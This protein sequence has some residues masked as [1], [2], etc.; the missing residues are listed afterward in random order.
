MVLCE[1]PLETVQKPAIPESMVTEEFNIN[2][3]CFADRY[4]WHAKFGRKFPNSYFGTSTKAMPTASCRGHFLSLHPFNSS[5]NVVD[6]NDEMWYT[7]GTKYDSGIENS[8][9]DQGRVRKAVVNRIK[10]SDF[11]TGWTQTKG[12]A[13]DVFS[14]D[15]TNLC[16]SIRGAKMV[17][18]GEGESVFA[19]TAKLFETGVNYTFSAYI[20]TT[21]LTVSEG[22]K[23]AFIRVTDGEHV[24][25]SEAIIENTGAPATFTRNGVYYTYI[26]NLQGD[27][28]GILDAS[29]NLVVEYKYD[30]W[31]VPSVYFVSDDD[32]DLAYDNPFRY[33]GYVWDEETGL[34]YLRSRY[35]SAHT[36]R[37]ISS[38][39]ELHNRVM[40]WSLFLY[41]ENNPIGRV[42]PNGKASYAFIYDGRSSGILNGLFYG[43]GFQKQASD[44][45]A[46]LE[47]SN[48]QVDAHSFESIDEFV[49]CW[50][51][52]SEEYDNLII[53]CHGAP[54]SLDC[55]GQRIMSNAAWTKNEKQVAAFENLKQVT[56]HNTVYL[57]SC[58]GATIDDNGTSVAKELAKVTN[59]NVRA[60][61][62][63]TIMIHYSTGKIYPTDG[64]Y[65]TTEYPLSSIR[66]GYQK[67][68]FNIYGNG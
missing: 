43:K 45:I 4:Q 55:S 22:K 60:V 32:N 58:N 49:S 7:Y 28:V 51:S 31:G 23:G 36:S 38:D 30:A 29:G 66:D 41:C 65:W 56:I 9:S 54:G 12:N 10:N 63:G 61:K 6:V 53:M 52:L 16:M 15:D 62:D 47:A 1:K 48:H 24:Y 5:G 13:A 68:F 8:P 19:T 50:D 25:E 37:F 27:I 20:K 11:Y 35:Y 17:K 40:I 57:L 18:G 33:R 67:G 42:D 21:G 39:Q 14:L 26:K 64:G 46:K 3:S 2:S 34:Y 59:C 44:L